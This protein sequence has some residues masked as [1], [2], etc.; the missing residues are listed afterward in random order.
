MSSIEQHAN[1]AKP[2]QGE[3][4]VELNFE[5]RTP[6][7]QVEQAA[8]DAG[9]EIALPTTDQRLGRQLQPRTPNGMLVKINEIDTGFI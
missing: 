5:S 6:L 9:L 7:E 1:P 4:D 2:E 8:R 3:G